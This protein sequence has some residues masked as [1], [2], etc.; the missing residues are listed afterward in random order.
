MCVV[1]SSSSDEAGVFC[2]ADAL[3]RPGVKVAATIG[4][5]AI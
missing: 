5:A 2:R 1:A 4:V 3:P